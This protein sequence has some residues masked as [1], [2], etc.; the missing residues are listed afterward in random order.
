M[1]QIWVVQCMCMCVYSCTRVFCCYSWCLNEWMYRKFPLKI[2]CTV[3]NIECLICWLYSSIA[4]FKGQNPQFQLNSY[5]NL[6]FIYPD[7]PIDA[8]PKGVV[9]AIFIYKR[10]G[11]D[12][13][14]R[15]VTGIEIAYTY[16]VQLQCTPYRFASMFDSGICTCTCV[17]HPETYNKN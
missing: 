10:T 7:C 5:R 6:N 13:F 14:K 12:Q 15:V 2:H 8:K 1:V 11:V 16:T 17:C 3:H 9:Y 4:R